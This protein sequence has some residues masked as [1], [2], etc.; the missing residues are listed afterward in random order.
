[1]SYLY[2]DISNVKHNSK[3]TV[4]FVENS[5]MKLKSVQ[6][7]M[8]IFLGECHYNPIDDA[9]KSAL[10]THPPLINQFNTRILF[11]ERGMANR[12]FTAGFTRVVDE[13]ATQEALMLSPAKRSHN[14]AD[15]IIHYINSQELSAAL[16]YIAYGDRH[17]LEIYHALE[18]RMAKPFTFIHKPSSS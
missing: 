3:N 13:P 16:I 11:L 8:I 4:S 5:I 9:V 17:G 10:F 15:K 7:I 6:D 18:K 12:H 14:V 1:M 2:L